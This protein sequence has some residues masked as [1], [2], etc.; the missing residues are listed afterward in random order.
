MAID[1]QTPQECTPKGR[2]RCTP[3]QG[4]EYADRCAGIP[5]APT[6]NNLEEWFQDVSAV[7]PLC[8]EPSVM[9]FGRLRYLLMVMLIMLFVRLI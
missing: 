4:T 6:Y 7:H 2:V 1:S 9:A 5:P 3:L 8:G